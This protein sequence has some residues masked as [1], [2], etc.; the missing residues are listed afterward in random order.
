MMFRIAWI[1]VAY[2]MLS[3]CAAQQQYYEQVAAKEDAQCQ[4]WGNQPSTG[5]YQ[6]CR[7]LLAQERENKRAA[8]LA[9]I[10]AASAALSA[11]NPP[12]PTPASNPALNPYGYGT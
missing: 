10:S 7:Y 5:P 12:P 8:D 3:G 6:Q 11:R 4:S 1:V 9:Q 2:L